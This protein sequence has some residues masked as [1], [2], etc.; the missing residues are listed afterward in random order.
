MNKPGLIIIIP[1]RGRISLL[2]ELLSSIFQDATSTNFPVE[3]L[4]IDDSIES[5][6]EQLKK[7]ANEYGATV[8]LGE[9]HVGGKRNFGVMNAAYDIVLFLDSDIT[10][11]NGTLKAHYDKLHENSNPMVAGCLGQVN[12]VGRTTFA[13]EV[14]SEMQLTLPFSYPKVADVVP[15]GPTANISFRKD[16]FLQFNGFDKTLPKYGGEDVDLGLRMTRLRYEIVT[17]RDASADHSTETWNSWKQN[18]RRVFLFGLADYHLLIRHKDKSFLDFPS[19]PIL[20]SL[21]IFTC[22]ILSIFSA[23]TNIP[24]FVIALF[25]SGCTYHL[26]YALIKKRGES[27]LSVHL[28]GPL[29]FYIMD[30]AKSIEAVKNRKFSLVFRRIKFMDDLISQDWNEIAASAWGLTSSAIVFFGIILL[31]L[32]Y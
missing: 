21:Q 17:S 23:K 19:E 32:F 3:V 12:F 14:I 26:V 13:W 22:C 8:L 31:V 30:L 4:L 27:K 18:I 15:W 24:C 5:D 25:I 16:I 1:T 7:I 20:L 29:I 10:I 2:K 9:S 6:Q 11:H 28:F